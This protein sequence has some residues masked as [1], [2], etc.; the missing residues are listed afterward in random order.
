MEVK[1]ELVF[2]VTK[3][4]DIKRVFSFTIPNNAPIGESYTAVCEFKDKILGILMEHEANEKKLEK[5]KEV[6]KEVLKEN[7]EKKEK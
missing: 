7:D 6:E 3:G 4:E 5:P 2:Q 1:N